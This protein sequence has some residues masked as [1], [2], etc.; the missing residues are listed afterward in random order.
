M[1]TRHAGRLTNNSTKRGRGIYFFGNAVP[2]R[3]TPCSSIVFFAR[4]A[5][6][7]VAS[8]W[9]LT[10]LEV[11]PPISLGILTLELDRDQVGYLY[12]TEL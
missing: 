11:R 10:R 9:H 2:Y 12:E 5:P 1:T 4:S 7:I 8:H 6:T 3:S